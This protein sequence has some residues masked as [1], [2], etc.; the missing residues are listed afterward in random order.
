MTTLD[1][2][3]Y[4][5]VLE[6]SEGRRSATEQVQVKGKFTPH[7][8][9]AGREGQSSQPA[10]LRI[11]TNFFLTRDSCE[12][13]WPQLILAGL[14]P[15]SAV[16][17]FGRIAWALVRDGLLRM[18]GNGLAGSWGDV[19]NWATSLPILQPVA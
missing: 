9:T 3:S 4:T 8:S 19:G 17:R 1:A 15:E 11:A 6:T 7:P 2:G 10:E 14:T 16:S 18:S 13:F 12:Q 5:V